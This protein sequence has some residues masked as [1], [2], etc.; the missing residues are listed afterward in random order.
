MKKLGAILPALVLAVALALTQVSEFSLVLAGQGYNPTDP[1]GGI[2][3]AELFSVIVLTIAISMITTPYVMNSSN[4][5]YVTA[6][7]IFRKFPIRLGKRFFRKVKDLEL[8]PDSL[9]NHIV[10]IGAGTMGFNIATALSKEKQNLIVVDHDSEVIYSCIDR[11]INC[12]YGSGE[13]EEI[14]RKANIDKAKLVIVAIPDLKTTLFV[15]NFTKKI[16]PEVKVF[17]RAHYFGDALTLYEN[18]ADH[19]LLVHI[20]GANTMLKDVLAFL[21]TGNMGSVERLKFEFMEY[22]KEKSVEEKR[23]FGV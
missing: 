21:R 22:L 11:G 10:V 17:A 5:I 8:L 20:L 6:R 2:L 9:K 23:H 4:S 19:V 7:S 14:L 3:S 12:V 16:N 18:G 15:T 13:T 1:T